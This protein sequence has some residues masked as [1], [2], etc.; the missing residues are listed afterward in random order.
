MRKGIILRGPLFSF[1]KVGEIL[2]LA[3]IYDQKMRRKGSRQCRIT[4]SHS[5]FYR[6]GFLDKNTEEP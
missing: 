4:K 3:D 2:N 5:V 6:N 1:S